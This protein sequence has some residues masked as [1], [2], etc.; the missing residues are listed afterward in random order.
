MVTKAIN[1]LFKKHVLIVGKSETERRSFI[2]DLLSKV[3]METFRSSLYMENIDDYINFIKR[4]KMY[5][6]FYEAKS[7]SSD[8]ILD[9]HWSWIAETHGVLVIL[10]EFDR[11][12]Q[13]WKLQILKD[14]IQAVENRTKGQ[15]VIKLIV[16]QQEEN[17]LLKELETI[18]DVTETDRRTKSQA[19]LQSLAV[20]DLSE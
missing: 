1:L 2:N 12:E 17:E 15:Q 8:Q 13:I 19:L 20:V 5:A 4:N 11:M 9:F 16:S 14:Y 7:Y 18:I 6:P 3:N 10:E